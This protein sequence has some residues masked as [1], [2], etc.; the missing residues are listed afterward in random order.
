MKRISKKSRIKAMELQMSVMR[1]QMLK[2]ADAIDSLREENEA[3]RQR[4]DRLVTAL[5][6]DDA[7]VNSA[8]RI[9]NAVSAWKEF[10]IN[11]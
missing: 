10:D 5:D 6:K 7:T 2:A 4:G 11:D 8:W 1:H 3:L 9:G